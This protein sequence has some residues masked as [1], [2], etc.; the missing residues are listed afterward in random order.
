MVLE[1]EQAG[2]SYLAVR[3]LDVKQSIE[4]MEKNGINVAG[5]LLPFI[6]LV[7]KVGGHP[8]MIASVAAELPANPTTDFLK[9]V[10]DRLP[11]MTN[12]AP[13]LSALSNRIFF[14][15]LKSLTPAEWLS[16]LAVLESAFNS[17]AGLKLA[18]LA[19][20][21]EV[22]SADWRYLTTQVFERSGAE[23]SPFLHSCET[24]LSKTGW[25]LNQI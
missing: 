2:G 21:I 22:G 16:R 9:K 5:A 23:F 3:G 14:Q 24:S 18:A 7:N 25:M 4:F 1:L 12:V 6:D 20:A 8:M 19:P 10:A 17:Q 11:G 15:V 13:F